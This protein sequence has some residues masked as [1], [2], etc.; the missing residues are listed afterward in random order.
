LSSFNQGHPMLGMHQQA[1]KLLG[2][3]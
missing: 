1:D 3:T 2:L